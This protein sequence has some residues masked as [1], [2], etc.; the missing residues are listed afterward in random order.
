MGLSVTEEVRD[1]CAKR[2]PKDEKERTAFAVGKGD[3]Q[4]ASDHVCCERSKMHHS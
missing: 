3:S 1:S 2:F 4:R